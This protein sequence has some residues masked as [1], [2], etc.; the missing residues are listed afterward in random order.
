MVA[1]N[2]RLGN[3]ILAVKW[4]WAKFQNLFLIIHK[5]PL[6]SFVSVSE[7][8][9]MQSLNWCT[10]RVLWST[11]S[12]IIKDTGNSNKNFDRNALPLLAD[13]KWYTWLKDPYIFHRHAN[14]P[15]S[16]RSFK[17]F[18]AGKTSKSLPLLPRI[19]RMCPSYLITTSKEVPRI[20]IRV[21]SASDPSCK[22]KK[23][24]RE[25]GHDYS[26][27]TKEHRLSTKAKMGLRSYVH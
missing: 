7:L 9:T 24:E 16:L 10:E 20:S 27:K 6:K 23:K 21:R 2:N 19:R 11:W 26:I 4:G 13:W 1:I 14:K 22:M 15:P 12:I 5:R 17:A 25:E 18:P 8:G 3:E